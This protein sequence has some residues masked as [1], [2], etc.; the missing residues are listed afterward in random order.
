MAKNKISDLRDHLFE[1]LEALKDTDKPMD[2]ERARAISGVAQV[3]IN[4]AKV[5][6]DLIKA[7]DARQ[8]SE[9]FGTTPLIPGPRAL[10]LAKTGER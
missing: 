7:I 9:F 1:T 8:G 10:P 6:V 3:I 5:E 4:S 2:V